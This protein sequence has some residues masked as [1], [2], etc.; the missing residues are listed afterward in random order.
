MT[1]NSL[2]T[3]LIL[4]LYKINAIKFRN[5]KLKSGIISPIYLD[6]RLTIS[7][8]KILKKIAAAM[9]KKSERLQFD[10]LCGVPYAAIPFATIIATTHNIPMIMCRKESKQ[11]GTGKMVDGYFQ[12]DQ[13]CLIIEDLITSG[14]SILETASL[15]EDAGLVVKDAIVLIDREQNGKK[16]L[17]SKGYN[18]HAVFT[19]G[20]MLNV[21]QRE[22]KINN[23]LVLQINKFL[24]ENQF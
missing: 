24:R 7:Y 23:A 11:H 2:T 14:S 5:F 18:I 8:P 4:D 6:L 3:K 16:L 13:T 9:W 15:I 10:V 20:Q 12:H 17:A 1:I 19:L 22:N 21:L